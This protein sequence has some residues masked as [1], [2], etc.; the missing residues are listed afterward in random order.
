MKKN[1]TAIIISFAA[2]VICATAIA[3]IYKA[4]IN[5]ALDTSRA[6]YGSEVTR[7]HYRTANPIMRA[8]T[9]SKAQ[10]MKHLDKLMPNVTIQ[11]NNVIYI[12]AVDMFQIH[13]Q[14]KMF[15]IAGDGSSVVKGD[16]MDVAMMWHDPERANLT[17]EYDRALSFA[18]Q[19]FEGV[20][21][22]SDFEFADSPEQRVDLLHQLPSET[23]I[24]YPASTSLIDT[25]YV[26]FDVNCP[27][28][29]KFFPEIRDL[30]ALGYAV[31]VVL[32]AKDGP[33]AKSYEQSQRILCQSN[34][35]KSLSL[36]LKKGFANYAVDCKGDIDFNHSVFDQLGL[37]GTPY[38]LS[39]NTGH[40]F[41]GLHYAGDIHSIMKQQFDVMPVALR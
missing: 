28:C 13:L 40:V 38:I 27:A 30:N 14:G 8:T 32:I 9:L 37:T 15:Y 23:V 3:N 16:V 29:A 31:N 41:R 2:G 11:S 39:S 26:F 25:M 24:N 36:F 4:P 20:K 12:E 22:D 17:L 34:P 6:A 18:R 33:R 1:T 19:Q 10:M 21:Q 7:A 5:T 35:V